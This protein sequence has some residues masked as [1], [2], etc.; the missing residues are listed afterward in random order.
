[1]VQNLLINSRPGLRWTGQVM[2]RKKILIVDDDS[3]ILHSLSRLLSAAGY[4]ILTADDGSDAVSTVRREKPDLI[5][6]DLIFPLDVAHG[7]GIAWDGFLIIDWLR[8]LDEARQTPI[9]VMTKGDPA[10]YRNSS[11]AKGAAAFF[12]KPVD[13]DELLA[14]LRTILG[15][16]APE[17]DTTLRVKLAAGRQI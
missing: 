14:P 12:P 3:I 16:T 4:D 9:L 15:G 1:M 11:F 17:L 10:H 8:R 7:G 13:H 2:N 5:L 6:L